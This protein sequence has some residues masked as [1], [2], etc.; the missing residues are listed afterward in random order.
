TS[1]GPKLCMNIAI[2]T[3]ELSGDLIG[4][5]LAREIHAL[6]PNAQLWGLGSEAMRTEGVEIVAD[7]AE[8]GAI[9]ISEALRKAP[10]MLIG[11]VPV[12]KRALSSR[13]PDAVVLVDFG[14]FNIRVARYCKSLG[15]RVCYY[16]PP[17]AWRQTGPVGKDLAS[18][19]DVVATP[20]HW[21]EKR[22]R[23]A[24]VK[25]HHVGHPLL[26]RVRPAL[27][28]RQFAEQFGMDAEGTIVGLLPGS[29]R[30]EVVHLM[31]TLID[32]A[33]LI[34]QRIPDAQF[35]VGV[36]SSFS[37]EMMA[38]FLKNHS[39]LLDRLTDIWHDFA[40]EAGTRVLPVA[41]SAVGAL[42]PVRHPALATTAGVVVRQ[43]DLGSAQ[44]SDRRRL[45][46]EQPPIVL[47]R[48]LTY[49]VMAHSDV[50]LVCSGTATLEAAILKAPMVIVY[51]GSR[52]MEVEYRLRGLHRSIGHIGLPN[53]L[54]GRR[55]VPELIQ[56]AASPEAISEHAILLLTDPD[57]RSK[58]RAALAEV[59]AC[60]GEPGASRRTAQIVLELATG[61]QS[62][63]AEESS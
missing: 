60:L 56:E 58:A 52:I 44:K 63:R 9:S 2:I 20:F 4:A 32:A 22:L 1:R 45:T 33:R 13:R 47:A 37:L 26:E 53:I 6:N 48:G 31:P 62:A 18:I 17:G 16:F 54:A 14:A 11:V 55:I 36:A 35:V 28:R 42:A 59:G 23:A 19:T 29:R 38:G 21:S 61:K 43:E 57:A 25:A 10:G 39:D 51:R 41:R 15:L 49:D 50:L 34:H 7:S 12:V 30:H 27:S 46:G 24:G 3:G 8:W 40:E 5:A